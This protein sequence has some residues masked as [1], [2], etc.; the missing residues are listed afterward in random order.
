LGKPSLKYGVVRTE[1]TDPYFK[2]DMQIETDK[3]TYKPREKV[4]AS[5]QLS[6]RNLSFPHKIELAVVAIDEAVFQ[7]N[8]EGKRYYDVYKGFYK[9]EERGMNDYSL[10]RRLIGRQKLEKKGITPGGGGGVGGNQMASMRD[11]F[12]YIAY[13]QPALQIE[14]G[15]AKFEF[16]VPD[17][18]T[19]WR[20]FVIAT[21]QDKRFGSGDTTI[22]V[23]RE[24]EIQ[25]VNPNQ[26]TEGDS[27]TASFS[28]MNRTNIEQL[29]S[30]TIEATGSIKSE[31]IEN[32][33]SIQTSVQQVKLPPFERVPVSMLIETAKH[34]EIE[35]N[36]IAKNNKISDVL[37][38]KIPVAKRRSLISAANYGTTL[39]DQINE[40]VVYPKT[41]H[42]DVGQLS[43]DFSST[44]IGNI[45]GAFNYLRDYPYLCWEQRL[46]KALAADSFEALKERIPDV[47]WNG[48]REL[49]QRMLSQSGSFQSPNGGM[50]FWIPDNKYTSPYLSAYTA[51]AFNRLKADGYKIPSN[52]EDKLHRYLLKFLRKDVYPDYYSRNLAST[53]RAVTL[54]A[55]VENGKANQSDVARHRSKLSYM[56][57][58]GKA[59]FLEAALTV[60]DEESVGETVD[61]LMAS[62]DQTAGKF[63]FLENWQE[64]RQYII[65]TPMRAN[66]AILS[67]MVR[68]GSESV[69]AKKVGDI[70]FKLVRMITQTRGS[71]EHWENTQENIFC[72]QAL[73]DFSNVY[74]RE[75]PD[76][77]ATAKVNGKIIGES[78]FNSF[79]DKSQSHVKETKTGYAGTTSQVEIKRQGKGRLY[80]VTRLSYADKS[81]NSNG[82]NA[83][84]ELTRE[85]FVKRNNRW[86][87]LDSPMR[88][89]RGELVRVDLFLNLPAA[90]HFVV[91]DDPVP[92]GL[93][94]VNKD[95][96]TSSKNDANE[97]KWFRSGG[98][99]WYRYD[100]WR[101]FGYSHWSFYHQ[102]IRHDAVRFYSDYLP[103]GN[104]FLSYT[105]QAIADGKFV[106][107]PTKAEEMYDPDV[108]GL[109]ATSTLIVGKK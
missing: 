26:L 64:G 89:S 61:L 84:I 93:E 2:I 19:Q 52:V 9:L 97:A 41:M 70:P 109:S 62:M 12:K 18:L 47:K 65:D 48:A 3:E 59:N 20:I 98:S 53:V 43:V 37:T 31:M 75:T 68:V 40:T 63:Q 28:L 57:L 67:A 94:A 103:A 11:L 71:R 90:R 50:S 36:I 102:E 88:L 14:N 5:V 49:P 39:K 42:D 73:K 44:V 32:N 79:I 45:S 21:D 104:Y 96:A 55:L 25:S 81:E 99:F 100:D 33:Q 30:V 17:N 86:K 56:S 1:V 27:F 13:W 29:V 95:L 24:L 22:R 105:A 54:N 34:G 7:L 77:K 6:G 58:F 69:H 74:E 51:Y 8:S 38:H 82:I 106:V 108:F 4:K 60:Q 101:S 78:Q 91:V 87:K 66:C 83:G 10:I 46:S 85:Y 80:Y 16:E 92:G 35:F 76:F 23:N 15:K 107:M 72:M